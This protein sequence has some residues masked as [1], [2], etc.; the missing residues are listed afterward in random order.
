MRHTLTS[1]FCR[2]SLHRPR[3]AGILTV[4]L[5]ITP[6]GA[7]AHPQDGPHADVEIE[8]ADQQV[9]FD[10]LINL[11]MIDEMGE[12]PRENAAEIHAIEEDAIRVAL[13]AYIAR[14]HRVAINGVEVTPIIRSFKVVRSDPSH[15][16]LFPRTGMRGLN[17]VHLILEYPIKDELKSVAMRWGAFPPDYTIDPDAQGN[18]PPIRLEARM[19]AEGQL[20]IVIFTKDEPEYT[21]HATGL[22]AEDRFASVPDLS[23]RAPST[24][25]ITIPGISIA[26]IAGYLLVVIGTLVKDRNGNRKVAIAGLAPVVALAAY[27]SRD[28]WAIPIDSVTEQPKQ[29]TEEEVLAVFGPLHANIYRAFDYQT[30]SEIYDALARSVSGEMLDS[31]Y[32]QIFRSLVMMEEGGAVS[33]VQEVR[34]GDTTVE[35]VGELASGEQGFAILAR[36]QVDGVVNHFGH[37][38]WRTNE[39]L[40]RF[41][42]VEAEDGWRIA[43]HNVLEQQRLDTD[44]FVDPTKAERPPGEL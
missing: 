44:P 7:E 31:L 21:F 20:K 40:A 1:L 17:K 25:S 42:V 37:S 4:F 9:V 26:L 8:I 29:L 5:L 28:A 3:W 38:H 41:G 13:H 15:V 35:S 12:F 23:E 24:R 16:A 11:V 30:E 19:R 34:L 14:E 18:R 33:S 32:N 27:L 6:I 10:I 22:S 2:A 43:S 39:Y 36:W